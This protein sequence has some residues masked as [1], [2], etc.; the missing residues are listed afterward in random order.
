MIET[1]SNGELLVCLGGLARAI[2]SGSLAARTKQ[3]PFYLSETVIEF[4]QPAGHPP[5]IGFEKI[6]PLQSI[7]THVVTVLVNLFPPF[8]TCDLSLN[9]GAV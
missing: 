4:Q 7:Q 3:D 9:K 1:Y 6:D 5:K 2:P 8:M